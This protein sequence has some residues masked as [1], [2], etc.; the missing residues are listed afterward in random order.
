MPDSSAVAADLRASLPVKAL[1]QPVIDWTG[2]YFGVHAGFG[3]GRS[4]ATLTDPVTTTARHDFGGII[5]GVQAGYNVQLPSGLLLGVEADISFPSYIESNSIVSS[6]TTARSDVSQQWDFIGTAR[7]RVGYATGPW[8]AYATGGLAWAGERTLNTLPSGN[9]EKALN[10]RLG[11]AAGAGSG[12][13]LR[14]ALERTAGISLLPLRQYK[15]SV[16]LG[17]AIR[18]DDGFSVDPHRPQ[19]QARLDLRASPIFR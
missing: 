17:H 7:G 11:W 14:A 2:L 3:G 6:L 1:P 10:V 19:S 4:T 18:R 13:R 8:L 15:R 9:Q 16:S 5:G 12:I